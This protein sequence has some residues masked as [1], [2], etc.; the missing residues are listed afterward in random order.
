MEY[1]SFVLENPATMSDP[2]PEAPSVSA[3]EKR[4]AAR[5]AARLFAISFL[6]LF[7][8]LMLIR[9]VPAV[10]KIVAYYANLMLISSFLGLGMG[11]LVARRGGRL[12]R[13]FPLLLAVTVCAP[14]S[15]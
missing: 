9:W 10:A 5:R 3:D 15:R 11:A 2:T 13:W 8:E 6:A 4:A 7:L 1:R 12:F 14:L